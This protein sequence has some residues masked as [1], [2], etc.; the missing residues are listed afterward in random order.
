MKKISPIAISALKEALTVIYWTKKDL[1]SYINNC[2]EHKSI[3]PLIDWENQC[4][5]DIVCELVDKMADKPEIFQ[6]DLLNLINYTASMS[7]FD[8]LKRWEDGEN[9]ARK[10]HEKVKLLRLQ[11]NGYFE[12]M[13]EN[14]E[15]V[16][17]RKIYASKLRN[18]KDFNKRLADMRSEFIE[19]VKNEYPQKRGFALEG[20]LNRLFE[21]F[22]LQPKQSFRISGEQIDGAF[23]YDGTDYLIEAKW[24]SDPIDMS[25]L[26]TFDGKIDTKLKNTL[27][28]F[29]S[30]G[31]FSESVYSQNGKIKSMILF[32][33][34]DLM[35]I[36][37]ERIALTEMIL[38]KRKHAS[39]TG[40][41]IYRINC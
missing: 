38:I 22:D 39:Q 14:E 8:H 37:E 18:T 32:D 11:S 23:T 20:F 27:G 31:G 25:D 16:N 19:L 9:K 40:E 41:I 35:Q 21:L 12:Q 3:I 30:I 2:I 4:K 29:L 5:Y 28:L 1:R 36:L 13:K 26:Y 34:Q 10:A 17:K 7:N 15:A 33:G 24:Q 6:Q